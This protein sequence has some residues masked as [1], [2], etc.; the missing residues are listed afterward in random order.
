[1]KAL[2]ITF[3]ELSLKQVKPNILECEGL[4]LNLY[5]FK[6]IPLHLFQ[7]P[8][9]THNHTKTKRLVNNGQFSE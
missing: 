9:V 4:N 1:M 7:F 6:S 2:Y 5:Y 3:Q 8:D